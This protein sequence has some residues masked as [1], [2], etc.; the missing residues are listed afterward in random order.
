MSQID[1]YEFNNLRHFTNSFRDDESLCWQNYSD[2]YN[3][4]YWADPITKVASYHSQSYIPNRPARRLFDLYVDGKIKI[5]SREIMT[6]LR[7]ERSRINT[8]S[9][10]KLLT[11]NNKKERIKRS[12]GLYVDNPEKVKE[13][14]N[15]NTEY[16]YIKD[17]IELAIKAINFENKFK[18][19]VNDAILGNKVKGLK[20]EKYTLIR[21]EHKGDF[22]YPPMSGYIENEEYTE[23]MA[24]HIEKNDHFSNILLELYYNNWHAKM[25]C[26]LDEYSY[27]DPYEWKKSDYDSYENEKRHNRHMK[28]RNCWYSTG[29]IHKKYYKKVLKHH[30]IQPCTLNRNTT[31]LIAINRC[32]DMKNSYIHVPYIMFAY[33]F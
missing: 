21:C 14:I 27:D 25:D 8:D 7:Y 17:S 6:L 29:P 9:Y 16:E 24:Y 22:I 18:Q 31:K 5:F 10:L 23:C 32:W 15:I 12:F 3:V 11:L 1:S 26:M 19:I 30:T 28:N 4:Q 2:N 13:F 33:I 20:Q